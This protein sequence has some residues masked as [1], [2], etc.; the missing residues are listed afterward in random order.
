MIER[1]GT[2]NNRGRQRKFNSSAERQRAYRQRKKNP[3]N[4]HPFNKKVFPMLDAEKG[5]QATRSVRQAHN[6]AGLIYV[7]CAY[8]YANKRVFFRKPPQDEMT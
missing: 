7:S 1:H 3:S 6:F 4:K 8:G 2:A 5:L